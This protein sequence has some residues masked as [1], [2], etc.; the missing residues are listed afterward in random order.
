MVEK[1]PKDYIYILTVAFI[2]IMFYQFTYVTPNLSIRLLTISMLRVPYFISAALAINLSNKYC[3]TAGARALTC[4]LFAGS[5][6]YFA[7]GCLAISSDEWSILLRTGP[8][9]GLNFLINSVVSIVITV[10]ISRVEAERAINH[11]LDLAKQLKA[12]SDGLEAT[13]K[14]QTAALRTEVAER[15]RAQLELQEKHRQLLQSEQFLFRTFDQAPIGASIVSLDGRYIRVNREFEIITGYSQFELQNQTI[16][17]ITHPDD[18]VAS[19]ESAQRLLN[20]EIS[21][22]E[23]IKRYIT[24]D[25]HT[26]WG[27]VS[28]R[29]MRGDDGEPQFFLPM[30]TNITDKRNAEL[31][32]QD[33]K[34][35]A[36]LALENLMKIQNRLIHAEKLASLGRLVAGVAHEINTPLGIAITIGSLLSE[37][38]RTLA[39]NYKAGKLRRTEMDTFIFDNEEGFHL[40]LTNLQRAA[41]LVHSFKQIATDQ[42]SETRIIFDLG[43]CLSETVL[44]ISPIWKKAGHSIDVRCD[45]PIDVDGYP[46]FMTQILTNMVTNSVVHGFGRDHHGV[47]IIT[48][49]LIEDNTVRLCYTDNGCGID[50][51]LREKVFE[52]FFTTRRT[53]GSTGLGLNIIYNLV[54]EKMNGSIEIAANTPSGVVITIEFPRLWL[55]KA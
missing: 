13:I 5:A 14:S 44:T 4:I 39:T 54:I 8:V 16:D 17:D 46:G 32:L 1:P 10:A 41:D 29:I 30:V 52:P 27:Q 11:A 37:G 38:S 53:S 55:P 3:S 2:A 31:A 26:V 33:A 23:E 6:W 51:E 12:Q 22:A 48:A 42:T 18:R 20:N 43:R 7:R 25:G 34:D 15:T 45:S 21:V 19:A 47:I 49:D 28:A 9:Q 35:R 36:E 40:L 50:P 24:R